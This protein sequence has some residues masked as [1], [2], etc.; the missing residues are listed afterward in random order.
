MADTKI[1]I[2]A[3]TAQ[4]TAALRSF[5]T[6]ITG[7]TGNLSA[8]AGV[9]GGAVSIGAF[10]NFIKK[11]IDLQDELGSLSKQTGIAASDLGGLKFAAEQNG[12]SLDVVAKAVK[13]LSVNMTATPEKFAKLGITA[14]D[15]TGALAQIADL[16]S[17]MPDGMQKTALLAELMGRKFGPGMAE[18]LS[19]GGA[20]MRDYIAKGKDIYKVTDESAAKAKEYKDSMAELEARMS[21]VGVA[22]TSRLLPGLTEAAN[23]M[24]EAAEKGNLLKVVWE[25]LAGM[26]KIPYDLLAP[27][28]DLKKSLE[29]A[30]RIKELKS[31]LSGLE[32]Y[33]KRTS[34]QG[35]GLVGKWLHGSPGEINNRI[36]S[37]KIEIGTLEKY[38][39]AAEKA[40][41]PKEK[42]K[43]TPKSVSDLLYSGEKNNKD[44]TQILIGLE[45]QYQSEL[46]K[47][48]EAMGAPLLSANQKQLAE[49]MRN[50]TKQ[51]QD[52]RIE[53]EKLHASKNGISDSDYSKRM[54]EITAKEQ[55]Q[56]VAVREL[57]AQQDK[58][59]QSWEYGA[60]VSV[61]KYLDEVGT[62]AQ[63]AGRL[64]GAAFKGMETSLASFYRNGVGSIDA[65]KNAVLDMMAQIAAEQTMTSLASLFGGIGSS[66]TGSSAGAAAAEAGLST[67]ME[68]RASGG[69][70]SANSMYRVNELGPELLNMN[71]KDYLMMGGRGGFVK[72]LGSSA[73]VQ[74][75]GGVVVHLT[76]NSQIHI[77]ARTD[78]VQAL[79]EADALIDQKQAKMIEMLRRQKAIT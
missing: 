29:A 37:L 1:R 22:I 34:G 41:A 38:G 16:V 23:G 14:K 56:I 36:N 70:V 65:L 67:F 15:A 31:E 33:M 69:P 50:V 49:D 59:N 26:A 75:G 8:F 68:F 47:R 21:G 48:K 76:D 11:S 12:T 60:K 44:G 51:A 10:S 71:G 57:Q 53:L 54:D 7:L 39:A 20:A 52:A 30:N 4:A 42:P 32:A 6:N 2:S 3:E 61:R 25:A 40:F 43:A 78:R 72:P 73:N 27:P 45:R 63:Q 19:Q 13:D 55:T 24:N 74:G 79:Q 77:D 66:G 5:S 28:E 9:L 35:D 46:A 18:F 64:V 62:S 58:L 17:T